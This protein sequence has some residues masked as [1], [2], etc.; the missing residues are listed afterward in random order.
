MRVPKTPANDPLIPG[1]VAVGRIRGGWGIK[2]DVKVE[3]LSDAP[4]RFAD[5]CVIY[6][7]GKAV[8]VQRTRRS[9]GS[10][11]VKLDS[12]DDRTTADEL[13]G[14]MLTVPEA[15]AEPLPDGEYYHFQIIDMPVRTV[16]GEELGLIC[17]IIST[18]ANDVYVVRLEG[19]RDILI[20]SLEDVILDVDVAGGGMTVRLPEGLI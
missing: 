6:L 18:G 8:K 13:R 19:R 9:K 3:L 5:G 12:V 14:Q 16:D 17:E 2:G 7:K 1:H 20:P 11:L 10:L 15:D 4:S